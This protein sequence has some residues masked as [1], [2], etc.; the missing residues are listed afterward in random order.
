LEGEVRGRRVAHR[1]STL[2][3]L[4]REP[5]QVSDSDLVPDVQAIEPDI[6]TYEDRARLSFW[7]NEC[8]RAL[9]GIDRLHRRFDRL[10]LAGYCRRGGRRRGALLR[11]T[12]SRRCGKETESCKESDHHA[13]SLH[14]RYLSNNTRESAFFFGTGCAG[15][16]ARGPCVGVDDPAAIRVLTHG[17]D[18]IVLQISRLVHHPQTLAGRTIARGELPPRLREPRS[19]CF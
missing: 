8:Q 15:S 19:T 2:G 9:V 1:L 16:T 7:P 5:L 4:R 6:G 18:C 10:R 14:D 3:Y 12:G 17:I 11:P 13:H